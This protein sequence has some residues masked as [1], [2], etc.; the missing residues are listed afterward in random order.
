[1]NL[2]NLIEYSYI[3]S[4]VLFIFGLKM[5]GSARTAKRG[6]FVSAVGMLVAVVATLLIQGIVSFKLIL[7]GLVLGSA[8]GA[9]AAQRV[10]MTA[11]PE[12]V[13][14][15]NGFGGLASLFV[16][17]AEYHRALNAPHPE[18]SV[19]AMVATYLAVIIGGITFTGSMIAYAK[20]AEL[21]NGKPI[22]FKGQKPL[23]AGLLALSLVILAIGSFAPQAT[24]PL[25]L[26]AVLI[27]FVLGVL[28]VIPIGGADMPVVISLLN[29]YSGL[30]A[31]AAGFII[32]N[33]VLVV[34][35]CLVGARRHHPDPNHV[36]GHEP[37]LGQRALQRFWCHH[38]HRSSRRRK[39]R[40]QSHLRRG[41]LLS[42]GIGPVGRRR[43]RLRHGRRPSA[44]RRPR[45]GRFA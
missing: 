15:F 4:A 37:F 11:M 26:A 35:G 43:S 25:F 32:G 27:S 2:R 20:L 23:N 24:Y 18:I 22:L 39:A 28:A 40:G 38:G 31:C 42:A 14:L 21:I 8:I 34:A 45:I 1:M 9:I 7:L 41:C 33:T 13:G 12:M 5:L 36:Q 3:F 29:S 19:A 44:A 16:G 17:W 6:N 30:A 10:Q